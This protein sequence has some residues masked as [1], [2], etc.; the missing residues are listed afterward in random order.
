MPKSGACRERG[1]RSGLASATR[2]QALCAL[3]LGRR[4]QRPA[5]AVAAA[6]AAAAEVVAA[7]PCA[8]RSG[9]TQR[10]TAPCRGPA[11]GAMPLPRA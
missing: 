8:A 9:V 3:P 6:A 11:S 7:L 5:A 10:P 1:K 4:T 2:P